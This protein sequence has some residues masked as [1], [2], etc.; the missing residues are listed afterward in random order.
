VGRFQGSALCPALFL[1]G[2]QTLNRKNAKT[3]K[4]LTPTTY[5][6]T[7]IKVK[8]RNLLGFGEILTVRTDEK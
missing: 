7:L 8:V 2:S 3:A 6:T 4:T 5:Q 1:L